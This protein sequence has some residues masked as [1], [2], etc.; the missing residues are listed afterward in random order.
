MDMLRSEVRKLAAEDYTTPAHLAHACEQARKRKYQDFLIVDVDAHHYESESYKDVFEYI[1]NPVIR[2]QAVESAKRGGRASML[3]GQIG[4]QDIGGRITRH[5]LRK[6]DIRRHEKLA[7]AKHRDVGMTLEWM[8]AMGVD[9]CCLFPTP[10]LFLGLHPQ[11]EV[12]VAM[13]RAY[14]RWLCER[15]LSVE[16]R[17]ISMLYLPFNDPDAAYRTV[18]DFGDKKG[19]VGFMVTSPRYKPVHDNAYVR[20]YALLEEMG[21]PLAFHAAYNW[22]DQALSLTN[23]FISVHALGFIWFNMLHM[24]NWVINGLPERFPRLK[25]MWIESGLTWAY[26]LMQR[27]DHSYMMRTSDCPSLKRKPSEYMREMYYS[28]QPM[29]KPRDRS[30]LEATFK[31]I[32]AETQLMWSSDY[33]HW[34][35][36]LPSVI[37]DLPFLS[38]SG[39]RN[40]LGGNAAK[41]FGLDPKPVKKIPA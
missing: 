25:V 38:E 7:S 31:M 3:G 39:R 32:N 20:T 36:D 26:C 30:I 37:Y 28:S 8:D 6:H 27:L 22:H 9:Y 19:V 17:I 2:R 41:A 15:I 21:K 14:N 18:K 5:E 23:R 40:I 13:C 12:E 11:V 10:M 33:P 29:E 16:P 4:Y 34:D 24:T 1:E 35:F